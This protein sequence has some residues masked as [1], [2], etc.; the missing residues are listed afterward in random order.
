[1]AS[2]RS[3]D[4]QLRTS[5]LMAHL[6]HSRRMKAAQDES[7]KGLR[8]NL[9]MRCDRIDSEIV[10]LRCSNRTIISELKLLNETLASLALKGERKFEFD[11]DLEGSSLD[12]GLQQSRTQ[13]TEERWIFSRKGNNAEIRSQQPS[14]QS[15]TNSKKQETRSTTAD[16]V[17]GAQPES[18]ETTSPSFN[19]T[20]RS[21]QH[22]S[23]P[24]S[25]QAEY[26]IRRSIV[27]SG[28]RTNEG[29]DE[30]E[31]DD[32]DEDEQAAKNSARD[33]QPQSFRWLQPNS[34]KFDVHTH[35]QY[36]FGTAQQ[37]K[38]TAIR[39]YP[40]IHPTS[41]FMTGTSALLLP[42]YPASTS[43]HQLGFW[44]CFDSTA[45]SPIELKATLSQGW[46]CWRPP[47]SST[48]YAWYP[49]S[50]PSG[51]IWGPARPLRRSTPTCS[52][53]SSS[54]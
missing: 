29:E 53:T 40:A 13:D 46:R 11:V 30:D 9:E 47:A 43:S 48:V 52:L 31:N 4:T 12:S 17:Y 1:M 6:T 35:F 21:S 26:D 50:S 32:D 19:D 24:V 33:A 44:S 15:N 3:G 2:P 23:A 36:F 45:L 27:E 54:W 5:V 18:Q 37:D 39:K 8:E 16:L 22:L 49:C 20:A 51:T 10:E 34:A 25:V 38:F 42:Y 14:A 41:P 28:N 7:F